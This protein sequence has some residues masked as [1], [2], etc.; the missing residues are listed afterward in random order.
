MGLAAQRRLPHWAGHRQ[1]LPVKRLLAHPPAARSAGSNSSRQRIV[2]LGVHLHSAALRAPRGRDGGSVLCSCLSDCSPRAS[3]PQGPGIQRS[4]PLS[5]AIIT[6]LVPRT[7]TAM[8][9]DSDGVQNHGDDP[10]IFF[11]FFLSPTLSV[12][13]TRHSLKCAIQ[14]QLTSRPSYPGRTRASAAV[15][16]T[17]TSATGTHLDEPASCLSHVGDWLTSRLVMHECTKAC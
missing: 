14:G 5:L 1:V 16:N 8:D 9:L 11:D 6:V 2:G 10:M 4:R 13:G 15:Q 17:E 3:G 12:S 7:Q